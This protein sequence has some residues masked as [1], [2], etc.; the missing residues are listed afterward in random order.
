MAEEGSPTPRRALGPLPDQPE[1]APAGEVGRAFP[2]DPSPLTSTGRLR[3][4]AA[5]PTSPASA[6][7]APPAEASTPVPPPAPV[8]PEPEAALPP[9]SG[10]R[11]SANEDPFV[12]ASAA[13]RRSA[14][15]PASP[16]SAEPLL[17]PTPRPTSPPSVTI[18]GAAT[19]T[20][21]PYAPSPAAAPLDAPDTDSP[22]AAGPASAVFAA[23]A[24]ASLAGTT[25]LAAAAPEATEAPGVPEKKRGLFGRRPKAAEPVAEQPPTPPTPVEPEPV[26]AE[27]EPEPQPGVK[28]EKHNS[29]RALIVIAA[30]LV[31]AL[32]VAA[33]I[34]LLTLRS[35]APS[36]GPTNPD[37]ASALDPLV[38]ATDLG[39]LGGLTWTESTATSDP[40][41]PLCLPAAGD[42]VP[43]AQRSVSRK[44][45]ASDDESAAF[46]QAID[47][48]PDDATATAAYSAR[49]VQAGTCSDAV[50]W[51]T[52]ANSVSGL[53]DAAISER[54]V[55][56]GEAADTFHTLLI[57]R[58]GRTVSLVDIT[59]TKSAVN[60]LDLANVV[61]Q[62]LSR[63]CG[64]DQGTCPSSIEVATVPP[65]AGAPAG[66]LVEGDV[67]RVT[68]GEGR[69]GAVD[70][71]TTLDVVGTQ[72]EAMD[73]KSVAGTTSSAQRT[74]LLADDV[75][76]PSGFGIDMVTYTFASAKDATKLGKK[77]SSNIAK[78]PD[79]A[80]TATVKDGPAA[81]GTGE[82]DLKFSGDTYQ[83]TQKTQ[84]GTV[85]YRV[86][87]LTVDDKVVYLLANPTSDFDFTDS[88]WK[89]VAVR[90]GQRVTQG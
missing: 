50:A 59:T 17:E 52:G 9:A 71:H 45:T 82:A 30:V 77:L 80:P 6:A 51:I 56:E 10:R 85:H 40:D 78:C 55:V 29:R 66:W 57:S 4:L 38:T 14:V 69:W 2:D 58:T 44:T 27:A 60:A 1:D 21:S 81:N 32:L 28:K 87:V 12:G 76:A 34:W 37:T 75:A 61:G 90:A 36:G 74:L 16:P 8:L 84:S 49:T 22:S 73:L 11:F 53:A 88:Q 33:G 26:V 79:R 64:G 13:P 62:A 67:P 3:R 31:V 19:F 35:G 47:T 72:C 7:A 65:P 86:G 18:P 23:A 24:A 68:P 46:V 5:S 20:P 54:L 25:T 41:R 43:D 42:G 89:A 15:S 83:V 70:P 63:Q 48:Y 39:T